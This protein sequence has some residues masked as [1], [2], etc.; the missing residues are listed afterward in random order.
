[1]GWIAAFLWGCLGSFA[2]E[3]VTIV[4][5]YQKLGRAPARY[6]S[7]WFWAA[8]TTLVGIAGGLAVAFKPVSPLMAIYIG[9]AAPLILERL[10]S[11]PPNDILPPP[12][13]NT[14]RRQPEG[15]RSAGQNGGKSRVGASR[16]N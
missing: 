1:M 12:P 6:R 8:R 16:Q 4:Q 13:V 5:T 10:A 15:P 14:E 9:V 3:I 7:L 2:I 11:T